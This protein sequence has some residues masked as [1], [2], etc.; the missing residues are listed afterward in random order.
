M[1]DEWCS[2]KPGSTVYHKAG[3]A[4][5]FTGNVGRRCD[6]GN[7]GTTP[8]PLPV[9][10]VT[11]LPV[12][13]VEKLVREYA[14]CLPRDAADKE[15]TTIQ[16]LAPRGKIEM[17]LRTPLDARGRGGHETARRAF[18]ARPGRRRGGMESGA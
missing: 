1:L 18:E 8:T 16:P 17:G 11:T 9:A 5:Y 3:G 15:L 13:E 4:L 12:E 6:S 14:G 2:G 7:D 10:P